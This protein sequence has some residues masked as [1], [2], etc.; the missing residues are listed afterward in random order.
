MA[1]KALRRIVSLTVPL[2]IAASTGTGQVPNVPAAR[3]H[4]SGVYD[5]ARKQFLIYGGYDQGTKKLGDVWGWN[6]TT[7]QLVGDTGVSKIVAPLAFD[8]KRQR[9]VMFGGSGD[10][11]ANDGKLRSLDGGTWLL[12]RKYLQAVRATGSKVTLWPRRSSR[13]T[14]DRR[15]RFTSIRSK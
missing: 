13:L 14:K 15:I 4:H 8:S 9:T 1:S 3:F 12:L 10:S 11:D 5:E 6:G 2:L 7:W